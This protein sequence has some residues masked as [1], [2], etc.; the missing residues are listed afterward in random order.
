MGTGASRGPVHHGPDETTPMGGSVRDEVNG[1][2]VPSAGKGT[3]FEARSQGYRETSIDLNVM[4]ESTENRKGVG[5]VNEDDGVKGS[6]FRNVGKRKQGS[7]SISEM[8]SKRRLYFVEL[9]KKT[10]KKDKRYGDGG[11]NGTPGSNVSRRSG[12]RTSRGNGKGGGDDRRRNCGNHTNCA[13]HQELNN[14]NSIDGET[15]SP[16]SGAKIRF[17]NFGERVPAADER[18]ATG[19]DFPTLNAYHLRF[20]RILLHNNV[21]EIADPSRAIILFDAIVWAN[22]PQMM[23]LVPQK[24]VI[25]VMCCHCIETARLESGNVP[26]MFWPTLITVRDA[27]VMIIILLLGWCLIAFGTRDVVGY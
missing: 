27:A 7:R 12:T 24:W 26:R 15:D 13:C 2:S 1:G 20:G 9:G 10:S 25:D 8:R 19:G 6:R 23:S 14:D 5:F 21:Q 17:R 22:F 18:M 11:C 4:Q 16:R 3:P